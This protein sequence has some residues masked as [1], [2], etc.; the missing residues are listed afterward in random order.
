MGTD[1][2]AC[3]TLCDCATLRWIKVVDGTARHRGAPTYELCRECRPCP[4]PV[5]SAL[6]RCARVAILFGTVAVFL[7]SEAAGVGAPTPRAPRS[8]RFK[9]AP[10][11]TFGC[12]HLPHGR[13]CI[14]AL[15]VVGEAPA[16][17]TLPLKQSDQLQRKHRWRRS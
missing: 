12:Q 6:L 1:D 8:P 10:R 11:H 17:S 14:A 3:S 2:D 13:N 9:L 15:M 4:C 16:G 5:R 7:A